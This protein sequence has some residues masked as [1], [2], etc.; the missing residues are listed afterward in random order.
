MNIM[1][2]LASIISTLMFL[3]IVFIVGA[4]VIQYMESAMKKPIDPESVGCDSA[5]TR[6]HAKNFRRKPKI[7]PLLGQTSPRPVLII[8]VET[9]EAFLCG[10]RHLNSSCP[11]RCDEP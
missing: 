3:G 1:A 4:A 11:N 9:K 7:W 8:D 10:I 5:L 6:R 2:K